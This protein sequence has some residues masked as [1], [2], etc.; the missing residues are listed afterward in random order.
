MPTRS[1]HAFA[2]ANCLTHAILSKE[3]TV[4]QNQIMLLEFLD[5]LLL[6]TTMPCKPN[7][8]EGLIIA[9]LLST[10]SSS[11]TLG[12]GLRGVLGET[13]K[14]RIIAREWSEVYMPVDFRD[15]AERHW[16]DAGFLFAKN[17]MAN[18]DHLL[19][20]AAECA[21]KAIMLALGMG[22]RA[23]GNPEESQHRVHI[24]LL[25]DEF[26]S[27]AEGRGGARY[28]EL[29]HGTPNPFHAW[30]VSQRYHHQSLFSRGEVEQHQ[31][32]AQK[33]MLIMQKAFYDGVVP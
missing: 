10:T 33:T 22:L 30:D 7:L 17:R 3:R 18:T 12:Q 32:A 6:V 13:S 5:E 11:P 15:A 24:N 16:I 21:L 26:V 14:P 31:S 25:W 20:M 8:D 1:L 23:D 19:G 28:S 2:F 27:F 29:L 4:V 9:P